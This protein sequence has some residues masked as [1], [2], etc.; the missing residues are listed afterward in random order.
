MRLDV[1]QW[2]GEEK[3]I[4]GIMSNT[5]VDGATNSGKDG[6]AAGQVHTY[7]YMNAVLM[8]DA[9]I[10][11][12]K[13]GSERVFFSGGLCLK[14]SGIG[15]CPAW[16]IALRGSSSDLASREAVDMFTPMASLTG[17]GVYAPIQR[18]EPHEL[19][20]YI[21]KRYQIHG[22]QIAGEPVVEARKARGS[23]IRPQRDYGSPVRLF[24]SHLGT[25]IRL[26]H[27]S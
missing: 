19:Q 9:G 16:P 20:P 8:I 11:F 3:G 23:H 13:L 7:F 2:L 15:S 24:S 5:P 4:V 22:M 1:A 12:D 21:F 26:P 6:A 25:H 14:T 17:S 10:A 27:C 18:L